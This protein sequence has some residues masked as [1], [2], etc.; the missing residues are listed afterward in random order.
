MNYGY[1]SKWRIQNYITVS[2][3]AKD[4]TGAVAAYV[5]ITVAIQT[6]INNRVYTATTTTNASGGFSATINGIQ[7]ASG[8]YGYDNWVSYHYFDII[9]LQISSNSTILTSNETSLYHFAYSI[10]QPH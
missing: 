4:S 9:P 5:P 2:G 3:V 6:T 1:G 8:F 7:P 10:Y